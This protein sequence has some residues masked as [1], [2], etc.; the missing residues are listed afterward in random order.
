MALVYPAVA[1]VNCQDCLIHRYNLEDGVRLEY[2]AEGGVKLPILRGS[3]PA[4]CSTCP[5]KAPD[6]KGRLNLSDR[7]VKAVGFY[8]RM[9]ATPGARHPLLQ[10]P[11]TQRIFHEIDNAFESAKAEI[12]INASK[13]KD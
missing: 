7:N 12:R 5:K 8:H 11:T 13:S 2:E 4:P 1:R 10:C 9:K 6:L 3:E